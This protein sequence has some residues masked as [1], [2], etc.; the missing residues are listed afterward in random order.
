MQEHQV[1]IERKTLPLTLPFIVIATQVLAGGEG[2]Y[3]LTDVQ[4]DRFLLRVYSQYLPSDEE[5]RLISRIDDI[6]TPDIKT[7]T[8]LEEIKE[9][10]ELT[11]QVHVSPEIV[12]YI[13]S[14]VQSIR[15]DPDIIYGLSTRSGIA[16]FKCA[17][18]F[19][20]LDG[21]DYVIPDDI[22]RL[23]YFTIEHRLRIKPEA[24]MDDITPRIVINKTLN[25]IPVPKFDIQ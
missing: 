6:D 15:N 20:I 23:A 3:P 21:R 9:L 14:I 13:T 16:L 7:V 1:T 18:V 11:K 2:T 19:A 4:L 5:A 8:T 24:E 10:Q 25:S 17:R 12:N 22:K